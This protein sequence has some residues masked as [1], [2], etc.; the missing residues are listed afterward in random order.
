MCYVLCAMC[1]VLWV[2]PL[3]FSHPNS[4]SPWMYPYWNQMEVTCMEWR[5]SYFSVGLAWNLRGHEVQFALDSKSI[6]AL[7]CGTNAELYPQ[8]KVCLSYLFSYLFLSFSSF[9][10]CLFSYFH[11]TH[12]ACF[13]FCL[14][15]S[16]W[17]NSYV[18]HGWR[19]CVFHDWQLA[20]LA[21][22]ESSP[23][24]PAV[25]PHVRVNHGSVCDIS[26]VGVRR[27]KLRGFILQLL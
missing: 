10:F 13:C 3:R 22:D 1:Y 7:Y 8:Q 17:C 20:G 25:L 12:Y 23:R 4:R 24:L 27:I 18:F 15:S 11:K 9:V 2:T 21:N 6:F 26:N 5:F 19:R 16:S 14:I